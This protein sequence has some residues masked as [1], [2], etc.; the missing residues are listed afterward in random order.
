M[1]VLWVPYRGGD[2]VARREGLV[3]EVS[4]DAAGG[5]EDGQSHEE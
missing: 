3:N 1:Q 2:V 5:R 4:A